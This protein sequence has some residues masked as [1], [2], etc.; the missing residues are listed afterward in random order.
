MKKESVIDE[1]LEKTRARVSELK[2]R[3]DIRSQIK[4]AKRDGRV[5]VIAEIKPA[6]PLK[7]LKTISDPAEVVSAMER[8]GAAGISVLT[9]PHFFKGSIELL[10]SVTGMTSLPVLR[11]DF[12]IDPIQVMESAVS[13]A[14]MLLLIAGILTEERLRELY[15]LAVGLGLTPIVEVH[16]RSEIEL[17]GFSDIIMINNRNLWDL[18]VDIRRT[19]ELIGYIDKKIVISASGI[20]TR[21]DASRMIDCGADA[22]LVGSSIMESRDVESKVRELVWGD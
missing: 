8:G 7:D 11:K 1:I 18:T 13:G 22:V 14:D 10:R 9:E 20:K 4:S 19:E 12:I 3:R 2:K 16:T 15:G 21:S 6:S 17:A 5:P